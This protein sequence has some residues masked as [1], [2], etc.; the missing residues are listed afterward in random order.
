MIVLLALAD[1]SLAVSIEVRFLELIELIL[2]DCIVKIYALLL[3]HS[4]CF[5]LGL[6]EACLNESVSDLHACVELIVGDLSCLHVFRSSRILE[7]VLCGLLCDISSLFTMNDLC[8]FVSKSLL[9]FVDS[10]VCKLCIL[11][12]LVLHLIT[13][14]SSTFLQYW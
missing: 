3:D 8:Y 12:D 5:A 7:K 11:V 9:S 6:H 2:N 13:S 10:G 1:D 4:S 14:A